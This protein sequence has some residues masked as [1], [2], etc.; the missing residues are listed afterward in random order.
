MR[1]ASAQ[2]DVASMQR[3]L[4]VEPGGGQSSSAVDDA[5]QESM[6]RA[7]LEAA[8]GD[9]VTALMHAAYHGRVEAMCVLLYHP[10]A[11]AA[12]MIMHATKLGGNA[13]TL[14][15]SNGQVDAMRL[16]LDHPS[17]NPAV[18]MA[19]QTATAGM[20]SLVASAHFAAGTSP[21]TS[22][23][24]PRSCM[25][26]LLLLRRVA[27][28]PQP[29]DAQQALMRKV[30]QVLFQGPRP[31]EMFDQDQPDDV[32]DECVCLLLEHGARA[33]RAD[34]LIV[35]RIIR[36]RLRLARVPQLI[37][38]AVVGMAVMQLQQ[39]LADNA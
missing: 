38:E 21:S 14:A 18:M 29:S 32:R 39:N 1:A 8:D 16:L 24:P 22:R 4:G 17:A 33:L 34:R 28:E 20:C 7:M 3:L 36:D 2:G 25:S 6:Q 5:A 30:M 35:S 37:N 15:T 13:L 31:K 9:G 11:D 26:L 12:A 10:S 27:L 19:A 23:T